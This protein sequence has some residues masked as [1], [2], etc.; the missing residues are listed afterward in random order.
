M[1]GLF[2]CLGWHSTRDQQVDKGIH[3]STCR[4]TEVMNLLESAGFSRANPYY[5]VQQGK[6]SAS[7]GCWTI[8]QQMRSDPTIG[9]NLN[10][11]TEYEN[12]W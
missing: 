10:V 9:Y 11:I 5:V 4:K 3:L 7:P 8:L 6:V 1:H 2:H 12:S